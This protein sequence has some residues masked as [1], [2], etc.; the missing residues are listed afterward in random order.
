MCTEKLAIPKDLES[1]TSLIVR[2]TS[3][4]HISYKRHSK[5]K[6]LIKAQLSL[7]KT[8]FELVKTAKNLLN[9]SYALALCQTLNLM[10]T[11]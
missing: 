2:G 7:L 9:A 11:I 5:E 3:A 8:V 1:M 6:L 10:A 4:E